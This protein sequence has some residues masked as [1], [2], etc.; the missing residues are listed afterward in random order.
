MVT[1]VCAFNTPKAES[2]TRHHTFFL[3]FDSDEEDGP[4][5]EQSD[6]GEETAEGPGGDGEAEEGSQSAEASKAK[7]P[8]KRRKTAPVP[9]PGRCASFLILFSILCT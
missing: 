7:S 5:D 1:R 4:E 8:K 3:E 9:I 6:D 2:Y